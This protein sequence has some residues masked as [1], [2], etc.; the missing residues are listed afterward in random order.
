VPD[1]PAGNPFGD[2][3]PAHQ[4]APPSSVEHRRSSGGEPGAHPGQWGFMWGPPTT[5]AEVAIAGIAAQASRL[6]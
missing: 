3:T 6:R 1:E 5:C 2:G 4:I